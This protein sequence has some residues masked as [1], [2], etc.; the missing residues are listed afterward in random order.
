MILAID[1]GNTNIVF[2]GFEDDE[3]KFI[4]RLDTKVSRMEDQYAIKLKDILSLYGFDSKDVTGCIIS[5]VVPPVTQQL[6]NGVQK[7]CKVDPVIVCP[8]IKTGLN[9]KIDDPSILGSDLACAA[10]AAKNMYPL[11]C[12]FA[13]VGTCLKIFVLDKDGSLL[14]GAIAPGPRLSF[15]ALSGKTASLPLVGA[16][17]VERVIGTNSPDSMRSGVIVGTACIID[18]MIERFEQTIGQKTDIVAT[19]GY[20]ELIAPHCKREL[21]VNLDLVLEGL[22]I[23]YKKNRKK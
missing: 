19:G 14:G 20:A 18:G 5:S 13:D 1:V 12:I 7:L 4:S 22:H 23:I 16:E 10:V 11:P 2:G 21:T 17:P 3:L 9:I 6:K 8:G 15:E